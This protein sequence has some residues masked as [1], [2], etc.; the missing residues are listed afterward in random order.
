MFRFALI[1][2]LIQSEPYA[3]IRL[4]LD[5][6]KNLN[7]LDKFLEG[8][9]LNNEEDVV[10]QDTPSPLMNPVVRSGHDCIIN[11]IKCKDSE[12]CRMIITESKSHSHA[13]ELCI[14]DTR[15]TLHPSIEDTVFITDHPT[16]PTIA[17]K[18]NDDLSIKSFG[19]IH[20]QEVPHQNTLDGICQMNGH[21]KM[22][23]FTLDN[24][25]N[26]HCRIPLTYFVKDSILHEQLPLRRWNKDQIIKISCEKESVTV[27]TA[28][29]SSWS[30]WTSC[31]S[32]VASIRWRRC[33]G[34]NG[35]Y[36]NKRQSK[37]QIQ[38]AQCFPYGR[39]RICGMKR[40]IP[41]I[42]VISSI[43][44][45]PKKRKEEALVRPVPITYSKNHTLEIVTNS[46]K[47]TSTTTPMSTKTTTTKNPSVITTSTSSRAIITTMIPTITNLTHPPSIS[48]IPI[49]MT[50]STTIIS[51]T[52]MTTQESLTSWK[53]N[54][55]MILVTTTPTTTWVT[56]KTSTQAVSQTNATSI[57]T[58]SWM[59][60]STR[61]SSMT[62]RASTTT[63]SLVT[64]TSTKTLT[65][66]KT[67]KSTTSSTTMTTVT[68]TER[69]EI[70]TIKMQISTTT[71]TLST[72]TPVN[73]TS[74]M[75]ST[76]TTTTTPR[77]MQTFPEWGQEHH[78]ED[79]RDKKIHLV[80][81]I[82]L[83]NYVETVQWCDSLG[84]ELL[85]EDDLQFDHIDNSQM[86][87]P[88]WF[89][90]NA[91]KVNKD[92]V[93]RSSLKTVKLPWKKNNQLLNYNSSDAQ[94]CLASNSKKVVELPCLM[95]MTP[96]CVKK[97]LRSDKETSTLNTYFNTHNTNVENN[98]LYNYIKRTFKCN[99]WNSTTLAKDLKHAK[100]L[101]R[102]K[103]KLQD[104][105]IPLA[106]DIK[107]IKR[108]TFDEIEGEILST[109]I[110]IP[111]IN[112]RYLAYIKAGK[113]ETATII[114]M[115]NIRVRCSFP[116]TIKRKIFT[117]EILKLLRNTCAT[118]TCN[119]FA[120]RELLRTTNMDVIDGNLEIMALKKII[121]NLMKRSWKRSDNKDNILVSMVNSASFHV[122]NLDK[123]TTKLIYR[124]LKRH[125]GD[126]ITTI[127]VNVLKD[128]I[129]SH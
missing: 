18:I 105:Q 119:D 102:R 92:W 16:F 90:V 104:H 85:E 66:H 56:H 83:L 55:T 38:A 22:T 111:C 52:T 13:R 42:S 19:V 113:S 65:A 118:T 97:S 126:S 70:S 75:S 106:S 76:L 11:S 72:S 54:S 87:R 82:T 116:L 84:Y 47:M 117:I 64:T 10:I 39:K 108:N 49:S 8:L 103:T 60:N 7:D 26:A 9:S 79:E 128:I 1:L 50:G 98:C 99:D 89:F 80:Q 124:S 93:W 31:K 32:Q 6:E 27:A 53:S 21:K 2:N 129:K 74:T 94:L 58:I 14:R 48:A 4:P 59:T 29:W 45:V 78:R 101:Q 125:R 37:N 107:N 88:Q 109:L 100:I 81:T 5:R 123:E 62:S 67:S 3:N 63:P 68:T 33:T 25:N 12:N 91:K 15:D 20:S 112:K 95:K 115:I 114:A 96:I 127:A 73:L 61:I 43:A 24:Q 41:T 35:E 36:C 44:L 122:Q 57:P 71:S 28:P 120:N 17:L 23:N 51:T 110:Y 46:T 40:V 34:D 77:V 69:Q 121:P 86:K 30:P